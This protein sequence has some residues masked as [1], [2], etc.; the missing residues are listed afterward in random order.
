MNLWKKLNVSVVKKLHSFDKNFIFLVCTWCA[1]LA[2]HLVKK[3]NDRFIW[4]GQNNWP[5]CLL[6]IKTSSILNELLH[7]PNTGLCVYH[8][9]F[10]IDWII[11]F[12]ENFSFMLE[13]QIFNWYI[14]SH[15][16]Q[17]ITISSWLLTL[18]FSHF[19]RIRFLVYRRQSFFDKSS[20]QY[21]FLGL[22]CFRY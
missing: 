17:L 1:N 14:H 8:I 16:S 2:K 12:G 15:H 10:L 4:N 5:K 3:V 7:L 9:T 19:F 20:M 21:S 22:N 18:I 6:K 13:V 11:L